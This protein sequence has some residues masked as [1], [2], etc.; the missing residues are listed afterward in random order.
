V[1]GGTIAAVMLDTVHI[2]FMTD[3]VGLSEKDWLDTGVAAVDIACTSELVIALTPEGSCWL[4]AYS[5]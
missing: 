5:G 1:Q 2:T 3:C 4:L